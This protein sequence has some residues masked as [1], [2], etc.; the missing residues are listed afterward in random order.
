[1]RRIHWNAVFLLTA[2][3]TAGLLLV[4]LASSAEDKEV[5]L[6]PIPPGTGVLK[7]KIILKGAPPNLKALDATLQAEMAK[8]PGGVCLKC[9][10]FEKTTQAYRLGGP[11][12]KQV[13]NAFV[14]IE[15]EAG[16]FF[17]I[18][19]KQI[20][21]AA[22]KPA[23]MDQPHCAFLPHC[24]A[25]FP[26]YRDPKNPKK[27]KPTGQKFLVKNSAGFAHNTNWTGSTIPGG[28][29]MIPPAK[30]ITI[31]NLVPAPTPVTVRCNIHPWMNA[32]VRVHNHPYVAVSLAEPKVKKA[33][34]N[35]GTY[36]IKN[37]PSGKVRLFAWHEKVGYLTKGLKKGEPIELKAGATTIKDFELEVP[38]EDR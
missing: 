26:S 14:W 7:G 36:E 23:E 38:K 27:L 33:E 28:N 30:E 29:Q 1:M 11:D 8:Q 10:D 20:E 2:T 9:E 5:E 16:S 4:A 31:E 15:P 34:R 18:D 35:F 6:R 19:A 21:E 32:W 17:Q 3:L 25:L 37:V 13:G 22:R 24:L 12:N